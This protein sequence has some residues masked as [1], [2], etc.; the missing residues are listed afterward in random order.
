MSQTQQPALTPARDEPGGNV[1]AGGAPAPACTLVIFG[2]GGDLTKRLLMPAL[3]NLSG[4]KLL[5]QEF[6]VVGVD[7]GE[8]D[9]DGW[10]H[11]L[12]E[13]MQTFTTDKTSEFY[14]PKIDD[15]AWGWVTERLHYQQGDFGHDD[16]FRQIGEVVGGGSAIFYLAV[17]PGFSAP[18]SMGLA[19]PVC[20]SRM[21]KNS[22]A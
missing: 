16:V 17:A 21:S 10:K 20:S 6:R 13:T 5:A 7:R 19:G 2:A 14:T 9:T 11:A 4:S 3:Y 15:A 22:G 1:Q 18:W 12:S 8:I